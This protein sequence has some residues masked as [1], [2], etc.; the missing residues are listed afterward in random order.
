M[1]NS[2]CKFFG[3]TYKVHSTKLEIAR[4]IASWRGCQA[5]ATYFL[6]DGHKEKDVIIPGKLYNKAAMV[7]ELPERAKNSNR[8]S[9]GK[10]IAEINKKHRF[11]R[12]TILKI[13]P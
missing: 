3:N 9:Q 12:N 5:D 6:T 11:L 2:I 13:D 8:I 7:L 4:Q 1:E 10:K